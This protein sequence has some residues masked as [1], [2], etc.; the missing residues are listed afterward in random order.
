M[1]II[2]RVL[3][4]FGILLFLLIGT[5]IAIPFFFKAQILAKA[6]AAINEQI[7]AKVDFSD[8]N[9][10][11]FRHFPHLD[12]TLTD[13]TIE[14]INEFAGI[15]LAAV[16]KIAVTLN[17]SS[18]LKGGPYEINSVA[19]TEPKIHVLV[20]KNGQANY[21]ITK[22][23]AE[24]D[25]TSVQFKAKLDHYSLTNGSLIYDDASLNTYAK[26]KGIN[27]EGGGDFTADLYDLTTKTTIDSL[28]VR[29][30]GIAYLSNAKANLDALFL[31]DQ[32]NSKYTLKDNDLLV[33]ALRVKGDGWIQLKDA[34]YLMDLKVSAPENN[35]KNLFSIIP[36]A[37]LKGYENVKVGGQ[38]NFDGTIKGL[39]DSALNSIPALNFNLGVDNGKVQ[40]PG[41]PLSISQIFNQTK[42]ISPG[43]NFDQLTVDVSKLKLKIGSNPIDAVFFLKTPISDPDVNAKVNGILN[44]QELSQAFPMESVKGLKGKITANVK[45]DA[46]MSELEKQQYDQVDVL[47]NLAAQGINYQGQGLPLVQINDMI[48][49]FSPQFVD[50]SKFN[51]ILGKSDVQASARIDN[52][53][54]YF[55]P[56]KTMTGHINLHS[57]HFDANEWIPAQ[58][59]TTAPRAAAIASPSPAKSEIFDRFDFKIDGQINDLLYDKYQLI[60]TVVQGQI[61]PNRLSIEQAGTQI[62]NSDISASGLI[63]N[64]FDY[65]F[66]GSNL[67]GNVKLVSNKLDLNQFMT[68]FKGTSEP[69]PPGATPSSYGV[70]LVP[71]NINLKIDADAKQVLYTNMD[72]R[73]LKGTLNVEDQSVALQDVTG[74]TLGGNVGFNGLYETKDPKKPI[75]NIKLDLSKLDFQQSFKTL[76]TFKSLAPI[77][78]FIE[79]LYNTTFIMKGTLGDNMMPQLGSLSASGFMET[80]NG[81]VQGFKPLELLARSLDI[82]E[83]KKD[84]L[85]NSKNWFEIKNGAIEVKPYDIKIKD[86]TLTIGGTHSLSMDMNYNIK[87]HIPRKMLEKN[88]V[89]QLASTGWNQISQQA[90]KLGINVKQSEYVNLLFNLSGPIKDPKIKYNLLGSDGSQTAGDP[91]AGG[92]NGTI[93]QG[94]VALEAEAKKK[95]DEATGKAKEEARKA[96]DSI[97]NAVQIELNKQKADLEKKAK[98]AI[99]KQLGDS[100]SKEAQ[101]TIDKVL[102]ND[103]AKEEVD[104]V[105]NDLLKFNPFKKKVKTDTIRKN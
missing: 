93:D 91:A 1:K 28:D 103:K 67:G 41:L 22:P 19:I 27:H 10:Y 59:P 79:G 35:F 96:L 40:Y 5:A 94:K 58:T 102:K 80:I 23:A 81:V 74:A 49:A 54:A 104:K 26:A 70:I 50:V 77:G 75:F 25:T 98:D 87:A 57:N 72:I 16:K 71:D 15:K 68:N 4:V 51:G 11:M 65:L 69:L 48:M 90:A 43:S 63:T 42:I 32:K 66:K 6:K 88:A 97:H 99:G 95:F 52:I 92:I 56:K 55:S 3:L 44:L 82:A 7:N 2:K 45:L 101:K 29:Y 14:G 31:V 61:N 13:L 85:L 33:N 34:G 46:K 64:I 38:F 78:K 76:N 100:L 89:G 18:I 36:G 47:G 17:L 21:L 20:S 53:L 105:K 30:D 24:V 60:N 39:Y 84:F 73:N 9:V 37:F 62:G 8:A 86:A 12:L 83:L